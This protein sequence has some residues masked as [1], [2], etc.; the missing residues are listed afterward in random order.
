L[1]H[2]EESVAASEQEPDLETEPEIITEPVATLDLE[3]EDDEDTVFTEPDSNPE[4]DPDADPNPDPDADPN[5][6]S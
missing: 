3:A 5:A 6:S 1:V 4:A 2:P